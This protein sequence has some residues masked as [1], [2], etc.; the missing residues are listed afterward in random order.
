MMFNGL[1]I[2][3]CILTLMLFLPKPKKKK[4]YEH[5]PVIKEPPNYFLRRISENEKRKLMYS[6]EDKLVDVLY[7]NKSRYGDI[8]VQ[9]LTKPIGY[10]ELR[11]CHKLTISRQMYNI[12]PNEVANAFQGIF[13]PVTTFVDGEIND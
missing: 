10:P 9:I 5:I 12:D 13:K 4:L 6:L 1:L 11:W 2:T 7:V 8:H 3:I